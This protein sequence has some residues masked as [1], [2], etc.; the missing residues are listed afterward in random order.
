MGAPFAAASGARVS[1]TSGE[2]VATHRVSVIIPTWNRARVV[3]EA[4]ES[5]LSQTLAGLEVI[6]VDD[7]STDDTDSRL[8]ARYGDDP[9]VTLLSQPNGGPAAARNRGL[10]AARG[11]LVAFLDS[12]DLWDPGLLAAQV[13]LLELHP[14]AALSFCD[15]HVEDERGRHGQTRFESKRFA[16]DCSLAGIIKA[17]FPLCTPSVLIRRVALARVGGFDASF[18]CAEDWD[19]WIRLIGSYEAVSLARPLVT[20]RRGPESLSR[21]KTLEKWRAWVRLWSRHQATLIRQGCP[22]SLVR[23]RLAHAHRKLAGTAGRAG[24]RG[25]ARASYLAWWRLQPWNLH[26]L[27]WGVALFFAPERDPSSTS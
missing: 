27:A 20:I 8:R 16:G 3:C 1:P 26:A 12:D 11:E 13:G 10:A 23:R 14:T 22:A 21:Q 6:V 18:A 19:L 24:Q 17:R 25:E 4:I 15:A 7:G 5:V 2:A 9:R